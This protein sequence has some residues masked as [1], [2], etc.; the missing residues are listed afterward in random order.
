MDTGSER[1]FQL[2]L[3]FFQVTKESKQILERGSTAVL[4]FSMRTVMKGTLLHVSEATTGLVKDNLLSKFRNTIY[5][6]YELC[7]DVS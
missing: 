7:K 3:V 5:Y 1:W 2:I 4:H 6:T